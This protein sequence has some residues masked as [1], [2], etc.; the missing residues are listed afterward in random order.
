M[1]LLIALVVWVGVVAGAWEIQAAVADGIGS[2]SSS[3]STDPSSVKAS[4]SDSLF[5]AANLAKALAIVHDHLGAAAKVTDATLYPGYLALTLVKGGQED[6]VVVYVGGSYVDQG[7][8]G[9]ATGDLMFPLSKLTV[10]GPATL[11]QRIAAG[12]K[13]PVSRLNYINLSVDSSSNLLD[14]DVYPLDTSQIGYFEATSPAG[15]ITAMTASGPSSLTA[16]SGASDA[17]GASGSSGTASFDASKVKATDP[18]SLLR[19]ANFAHALATLRAHLGAGVEVTDAALYPGYLSL[20][21]VKSGQEADVYI[22]AEG[23]YEF[24]S[25]G[26]AAGDAVFPLSDLAA[27]GP[28]TLAHRIAQYGGTPTSQLGYM[29]IDVDPTS[30]RVQWLVYTLPGSRVEFFQAA[31]PTSLIHGYLADG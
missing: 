19:T 22:D 12:A 1:R 27:G 20:T 8:G 2:S 7:T 21:V 5:R 15:P 13:I 16:A 23:T 30:N 9:D 3:A 10:D 24:N 17:A 4:N 25:T 18:L 29:V 14:W 31:S 11:T 26:G 6:H 28:A